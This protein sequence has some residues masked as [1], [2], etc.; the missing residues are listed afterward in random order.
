MRTDLAKVKVKVVLVLNE[1][2]HHENVWGSRHMAPLF[3][4]SVLDRGKKWSTSRPGCFTP[5]ERTAVNIG[6]ETGWAP[7]AGLDA[8]GERTNL[9]PVP[10]CSPSLYRLSYP[11][12]NLRTFRPKFIVISLQ[13]CRLLWDKRPKFN[14]R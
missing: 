1:A 14:S 3:L 5:G 7:R 11:R 13:L 6:W 10:P 4:I 12:N 2:L 8:V 9:L